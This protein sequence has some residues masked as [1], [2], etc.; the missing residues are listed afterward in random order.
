MVSQG[1]KKLLER[2]VREFQREHA[3]GFW[4]RTNDRTSTSAYVNNQPKRNKEN[5]DGE[6]EKKHTRRRRIYKQ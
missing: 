4:M 6:G 5:S 2:K 3:A 1:K